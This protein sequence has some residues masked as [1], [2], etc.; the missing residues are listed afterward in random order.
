MSLADSSF[1]SHI[2]IVTRHSSDS[3]Y[4]T[5][6]DNMTVGRVV[7]RECE[8]E[9]QQRCQHQSHLIARKYSS[10]T[11]DMSAMRSE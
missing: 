3:F 7:S 8:K 2:Q 9:H 6:V 4:E 11:N 5:I 10:K 1:P